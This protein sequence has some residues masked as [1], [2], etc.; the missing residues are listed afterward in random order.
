[1]AR[2]LKPGGEIL[3]LLWNHGNDG[4][5]PFDLPEARARG[6]FEPAFGQVRLEPV[7]DALRPGEYLLRARAA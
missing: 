2:A 6:L 3:A 7:A 1:M 5:P 4:G